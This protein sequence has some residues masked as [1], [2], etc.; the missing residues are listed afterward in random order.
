MR[1]T[2]KIKVDLAKEFCCVLCGNV[3]KRIYENEIQ[4]Y[5]NPILPLLQEVVL[6]KPVCIGCKE[7]IKKTRNPVTV[8]VGGQRSVIFQ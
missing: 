1:K 7:E 3:T 2:R 8:V 6:L 4:V 5:L